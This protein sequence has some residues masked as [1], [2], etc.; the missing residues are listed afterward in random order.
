LSFQIAIPRIA[1]DT[2]LYIGRDH[3]SWDRTF[4]E[5]RNESS[6]DAD[7][8][9]KFFPYLWPS[10]P[11]LEDRR[12][13]LDVVN[14]YIDNAINHHRTL[15]AAVA[16]IPEDGAINGYIK[17][18]LR[19]SDFESDHSNDPR[20]NIFGQQ[21]FGMHHRQVPGTVSTVNIPSLPPDF[22]RGCKLNPTDRNLLTFCMRLASKDPSKLG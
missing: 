9:A 12:L 16:S 2:P 20:R 1:I 14:P 22:G 17:F 6:S 7:V 21:A 5:H 4:Q 10:L 18:R 13:E 3:A 19:M 15:R 11:S 8:L